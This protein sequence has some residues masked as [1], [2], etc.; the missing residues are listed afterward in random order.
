MH[1]FTELLLLQA[2]QMHRCDGLKKKGFI[3]LIISYVIVSSSFH[4]FLLLFKEKG[5]KFYK[6]NEKDQK[7]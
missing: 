1:A 4:Q 5:V 6:M 3:L 2:Y 7:L